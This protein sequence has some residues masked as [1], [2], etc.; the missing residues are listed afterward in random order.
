MSSYPIYTPSLNPSPAVKTVLAW[1]AGCQAWDVDAIAVTMS[2]QSYTHEVLPATMNLPKSTSKATW[3]GGFKQFIHPM[4]TKWDIIIHDI[5]EAPGGSVFGHMTSDG[6]T[7]ASVPTPSGS[8]NIGAPFHNEYMLQFTVR[9]EADGVHRIV[10]IKEFMDTLSQAK[11]CKA[12]G[13]PAGF[14][15]SLD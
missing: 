3:L 8:T 4:F 13:W 1:V 2:D 9:E 15:P 10:H 11:F 5:V 14:G 12:V 6:T 7:T